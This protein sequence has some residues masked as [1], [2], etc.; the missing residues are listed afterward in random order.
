MGRKNII[1]LPHA[2]MDLVAEANLGRAIAGVGGWLNFKK[3]HKQS[4]RIWDMI[5]KDD[6]W[7]EAVSNISYGDARSRPDP[8]LVGANLAKPKYLALLISDWGGDAYYARDKLYK[9][10]REQDY[11]IDENVSEVY[12]KGS[13]ITL[14]I[15]DVI[16]RAEWVVMENP[17][18]LFRRERKQLWTSALHYHDD[19]IRQIGPNQIGGIEGF[20]TKKKKRVKYI[21]S[22]EFGNGEPRYRVLM[23]PNLPRLVNK[24][25]L[26]GNNRERLRMW[27]I[28]GVNEKEWSFVTDR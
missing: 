22:I 18:R 4:A 25:I 6:E 1:E 27:R 5:F 3:E 28:A 19:R 16:E 2:A 9:S 14:H 24:P 17:G 7:L 21:C 20:S 10:F 12:F 23:R 26:D 15:G 13:G 8:V 11:D